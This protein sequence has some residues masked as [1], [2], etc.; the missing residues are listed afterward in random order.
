AFLGR[1][2]NTRLFAADLR[3]PDRI[4][5]RHDEIRVLEKLNTP[6]LISRLIHELDLPEGQILRTLCGLLALG[7]LKRVDE[8]TSGEVTGEIPASETTQISEVTHFGE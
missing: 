1:P 7:V 8:E 3:I 6:Q 2:E 5:L 4:T